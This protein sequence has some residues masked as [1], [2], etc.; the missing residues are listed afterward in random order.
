[1]ADRIWKALFVA[2][3]ALTL[4]LSLLPFLWFV[5]TSLKTQTEVTSIPLVILPGGS[6]EFYRSALVN[7]QLLHFL[8][9]SIVVAGLTTI[10]T[11]VL[12]IFAGYALARIP[13]PHKGLVMGGL[14]LV[15]MFPQ[16]SVAGPVWKILDRLGWLNSYQGLVVPYIA[17]TPPLGQSSHPLPLSHPAHR[18]S[19]TSSL[20]VSCGADFSTAL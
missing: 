17:L 9:N 5:A 12:S 16:I 2:G 6:L 11:L 1:M 19:S 18:V 10:G 13:I 4:A 8:K 7:Y 15:S 14:L 3:T 20:S